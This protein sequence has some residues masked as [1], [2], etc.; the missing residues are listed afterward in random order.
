MTSNNTTTTA[1]APDYVAAHLELAQ[2][3]H[4][5]D[6]HRPENDSRKTQELPIITETLALG[7]SPC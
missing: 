7:G 1:T 2:R 6:S 3:R 5:L 4:V